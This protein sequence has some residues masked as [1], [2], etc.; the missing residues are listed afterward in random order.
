MTALQSLLSFHIITASSDLSETKTDII[1]LHWSINV[2]GTHSIPQNIIQ[3]GINLKLWMETKSFFVFTFSHFSSNVNAVIQVL[4]VFHNSHMELHLLE[5][6][7]L[8]PF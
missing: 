8:L 7:F 5:I 3:I 4:S 6:A 1:I 2:S